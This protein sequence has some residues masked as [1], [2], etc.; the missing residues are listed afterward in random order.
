M[1]SAVQAFDEVILL[2]RGGEV[3]Y[4]GPLGQQSCALVDYFESIPGVARIAPDYNPAT[5]ML[6]ISTVSAEMRLHM[7]LA[8]V[9]EQS[10]LARYADRPLQT[11]GTLT[12]LK[13]CA[14]IVVWN[15]L[16]MLPDRRSSAAELTLSLTRR[17]DW[18]MCTCLQRQT[19]AAA[20]VRDSVVSAI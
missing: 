3:I 18:H 13:L 11:V 7:D 15:L 14:S 19:K 6:E 8:R 9:Y 16:D 4:N 17:S 2:K 1:A 12:F 5:W 10:H 20:F